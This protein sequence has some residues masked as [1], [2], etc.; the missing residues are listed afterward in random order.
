MSKREFRLDNEYPYNR[1]GPVR[2]INSHLWRY[3][4][5]P[6]AVLVTAVFNN[7]A[8]SYIQVIIGKVST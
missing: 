5:L 1:R 3:A 8:Y 4:W 6:V 7:F 2:W